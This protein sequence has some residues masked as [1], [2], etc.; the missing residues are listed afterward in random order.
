MWTVMPRWERSNL[1][2]LRYNDGVIQDGHV[3]GLDGGILAALDLLGQVC[4][5]LLADVQ[6]HVRDDP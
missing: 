1:F 6:A 3:Y 4:R 5:P 2:K